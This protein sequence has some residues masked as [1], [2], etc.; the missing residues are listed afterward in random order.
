MAISARSRAPGGARDTSEHLTPPRSCDGQHG[1]RSSAPRAS[2]AGGNDRS[3]PPDEGEPRVPAPASPA[4]VRGPRARAQETTPPSSSSRGG[5]GPSDA[6]EPWALRGPSR[7]RPGGRW[8]RCPAPPPAPHCKYLSHGDSNLS[9]AWRA[10]LQDE[11]PSRD[12]E[13][14]P[15]TAG[16]G[17]K[18]LQQAR[19]TPSRR[20]PSTRSALRLCRGAAS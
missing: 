1:T 16:S 2:K 17:Q 3:H 13:L 8:P 14:T 10:V 4:G 5:R 15:S 18:T 11:R 19:S 12:R 9:P 20:D 7:V 6:R